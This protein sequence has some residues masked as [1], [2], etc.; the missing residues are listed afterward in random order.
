MEIE[1]K[2]SLGQGFRE[3]LRQC[4]PRVARGDAIVAFRLQM[5]KEPGDAVGGEIDEC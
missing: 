1:K 4:E 5:T 3:Y 2:R